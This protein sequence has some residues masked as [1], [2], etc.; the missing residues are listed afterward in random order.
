MSLDDSIKQL[1]VSDIEKRGVYLLDNYARFNHKI[2]TALYNAGA[3]KEEDLDKA[4][5]G[6]VVCTARKDFARILNHGYWPDHV[7]SPECLSYA[8]SHAFL[9]H[10]DVRRIKFDHGQNAGDFCRHYN[11]DKLIE[12]LRGKFLN[13]SG[14]KEYM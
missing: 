6:A 11:S 2:I 8:I 5:E 4:I 3:L 13:P 12:N 1:V 10:D 14:C 9:S 7:G